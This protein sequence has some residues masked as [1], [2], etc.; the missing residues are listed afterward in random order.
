MGLL[1]DG[2]AVGGMVGQLGVEYGFDVL[3]LGRSDEA[4]DANRASVRI[5]SSLGIT[6][7]GRGQEESFLGVASYYRRFTISRAVMDYGVRPAATY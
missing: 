4:V 1:G 2:G 7:T 3:G 6:K 5:L